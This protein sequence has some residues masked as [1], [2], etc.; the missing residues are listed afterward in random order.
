MT[1]RLIFLFIATLNF[2]PSRSVFSQS[3]QEKVIEFDDTRTILW[4]KAFE[5]VQIPGIYNTFQ[6]AYFYKTTSSKPQPL[7]ISLHTWGGSYAQRDEIAQLSTKKNYNYIHPDFRGPNKTVNACCSELALSDID[8]AIDYAISKGNVDLSKIFVI[9]VSGGGFATLN[10]FMNSK[11]KIR[12][13]SA[14][15]SITDL[16][17]W[18]SESQAKGN[19]YWKDISLCTSGK[20]GELGLAEA[21]KRSPIFKETPIKKLDETKLELYAGVND[22]V[23]G[24]VPFTHSILFYNKLL[25][26]LKV[27]DKK[28]YVSKRDINY[29]LKFRKPRGDLGKIADRTICLA[30]QYKNIKLTIFNG[31][32]EMLTDYAFT[33]LFN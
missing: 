17:K 18:Y 8:N 19:H 10:V 23:D 4:P 3:L 25:K 29:L 30:K 33:Q 11:H 2:I 12:K 31:G 27:S 6:K 21:K 9:G 13:F 22:G 16:E 7:I 28:Y 1:L 14:W 26:D 15:A 32:H 20:D 5:L 24:S